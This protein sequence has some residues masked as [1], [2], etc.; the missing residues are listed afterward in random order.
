MKILTILFILIMSVSC[1]EQ[2]QAAPGPVFDKC[3]D[4]QYIKD[5]GDVKMC[6]NNSH[7]CYLGWDRSTLFCFK[8]E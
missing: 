5:Y 6:E 1:C 8:K 3:T 4:T 7:I 2:N